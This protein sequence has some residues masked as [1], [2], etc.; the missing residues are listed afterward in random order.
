MISMPFLILIFLLLSIFITF[1]FRSENRKYLLI[2]VSILFCGFLSFDL[3]CALVWYSILDILFFKGVLSS[4][5]LFY[6]N[7]ATTAVAFYVFS[8]NPLIVDLVLLNFNLLHFS[9]V[10][11]FFNRI[12]DMLENNQFNNVV[13]IFFSNL[14]LKNFLQS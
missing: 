4:K 8:I 6:L 11:I 13:D 10:I 5:I 14:F 9:L 2:S 3:L 12:N 1:L 7:M